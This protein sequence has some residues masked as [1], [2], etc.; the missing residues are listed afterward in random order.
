MRKQHFEDEDNIYKHTT[1]CSNTL[2]NERDDVFRTHT[3]KTHKS[4][5][6]TS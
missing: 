1:N 6:I 5:L 3:K 4:R 2:L